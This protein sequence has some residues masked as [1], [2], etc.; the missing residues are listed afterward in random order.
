[1]VDICA[2]EGIAWY[3]F[4]NI[5]HAAPRNLRFSA[6]QAHKNRPSR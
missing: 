4:P 1:M 3:S 2:G 5:K 6:V